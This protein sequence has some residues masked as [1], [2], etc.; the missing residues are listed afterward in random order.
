M[1]A[2]T[3]PLLGALL[4]AFSVPNPAV[5][6]SPTVVRRDIVHLRERVF[7]IRDRRGRIDL[8]VRRAR[9]RGDLGTLLREQVRW[10]FALR[11]MRHA[12][13]IWRRTP[14]WDSW[15]C[16]H[17]R[18]GAWND[19]N[20]PYWGGLQMDLGFQRAY[21]RELLSRYGTADH[22]PIAAQVAVAERAYRSRSFHPWPNT[23]RACGLR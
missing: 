8:V 3:L 22:W 2:S 6:V 11:R 1:P 13:P 16:I 4:A 23:A 12:V 10:R 21:G 5:P 14:R 9:L 17:G 15:M 20:A 19:P 7:Q 18:E